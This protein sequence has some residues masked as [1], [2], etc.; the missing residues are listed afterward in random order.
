M[1][2][3]LIKSVTIF[4]LLIA[5]LTFPVASEENISPCPD[6]S[7]NESG[8]SMT[9]SGFG[10]TVVGLFKRHISPIDGNRCPMYPSCSRYSLNAFN[11]HGLLMGWVM[12]CDRLLRCG[13]DE[14]LT[15]PRVIVDGGARCYDSVEDNDF[16]WV[17]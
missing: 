10:S 14:L 16:W 6:K 15:A 2:V 13:R 3:K 7:V 8:I 17:K 11:K 4:V 1:R 5:L 12:T 9:D